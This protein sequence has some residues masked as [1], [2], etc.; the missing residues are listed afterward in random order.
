[1]PLAEADLVNDRCGVGLA[2]RCHLHQVFA[3]S[4]EAGVSLAACGQ[5]VAAMMAIITSDD[6]AWGNDERWGRLELKTPTQQG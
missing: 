3:G 5:L 2:A 1:M 4:D 6:V